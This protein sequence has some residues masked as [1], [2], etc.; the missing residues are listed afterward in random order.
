MA[1]SNERRAPT[2]TSSTACKLFSV[3]ES[4]QRKARRQKE[5]KRSAPEQ[6]EA[7]DCAGEVVQWCENKKSD[8]KQRTLSQFGIFLLSFTPTF[9]TLVVVVIE[10]VV[11]ADCLPVV[12]QGWG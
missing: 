9:G 12:L 6:H 1:K 2:T 4:Y 3:G 8:D 10:S 5:R 7:R 11:Q